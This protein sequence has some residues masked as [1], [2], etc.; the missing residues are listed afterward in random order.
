MTVLCMS[1]PDYCLQDIAILTYEDKQESMRYIVLRCGI[2]RHKELEERPGLNIGGQVG[3]AIALSQ[4]SAVLL[5]NK[6]ASTLTVNKIGLRHVLP[7]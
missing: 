4:G 2:H 3:L 7:W 5:H 1:L 6:G